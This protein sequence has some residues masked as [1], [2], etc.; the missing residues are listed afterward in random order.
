MHSVTQ[1]SPARSATRR[2]VALAALLTAAFTLS[3]FLAPAAS[4]ATPAL[5]GCSGQATSI[6]ADG[7]PLS[8]LVV[9]SPQEVN[10][11]LVT[12]TVGDPFRVSRDGTIQ[13]AGNTDEAVRDNSWQLSVFGVPV[14]NGADPNDDGRTV[15]AGQTKVA[16][17]V[18]FGLTGLYRVRGSVSGDGGRCSGS[19][20]VRVLGNPAGSVAWFGA[21]GLIAVGAVVLFAA[22][23]RLRPETGLGLDEEAL[24]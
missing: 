20:W 4:A 6:A 19:L 5:R 9:P 12:G 13:F 18:P 15:L 1:S 11:D 8:T 24:V 21:L 10:P 7:T 17:E 16:E 23:P 22:R 14:R 2:V 3:A